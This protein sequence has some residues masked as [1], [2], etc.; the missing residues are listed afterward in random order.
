[1]SGSTHGRARLGADTRGDLILPHCTTDPK[2]ELLC[3]GSVASLLQGKQPACTPYGVTTVACS[4]ARP[5]PRTWLFTYRFR[6]NLS[7]GS[8]NALTILQY[9]GYR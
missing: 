2:G 8:V 1:M 3:Q 6:Q 5:G 4:L 9:S 7:A